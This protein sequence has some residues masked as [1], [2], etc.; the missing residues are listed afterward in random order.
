MKTELRAANPALVQNWINVLDSLFLFLLYL[1][2]RVP[3]LR[4]YKQSVG[5]YAAQSVLYQEE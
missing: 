2:P 5:I 3:Y 4:R 1:C